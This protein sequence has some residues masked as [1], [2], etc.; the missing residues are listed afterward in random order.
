[1]ARYKVAD[2]IPRLFR[3]I[4]MR[5]ITQTEQRG[6]EHFKAARKDEDATRP[7]GCPARVY[8]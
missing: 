2:M 7:L 6:G 5:C 1:M 3:W 8:C 4:C